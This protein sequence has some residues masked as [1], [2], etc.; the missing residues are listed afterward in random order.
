VML[1]AILVFSALAALV[2]LGFREIDR[3]VRK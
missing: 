2:F 1:W 3:R